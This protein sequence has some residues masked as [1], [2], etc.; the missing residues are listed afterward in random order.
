MWKRT[1][2]GVPIISWEDGSHITTS[3]TPES[4]SKGNHVEI[5]VCPSISLV[6]KLREKNLEILPLSD[7]LPKLSK[8]GWTALNSVPA[9]FNCIEVNQTTD[10]FITETGFLDLEFY[11]MT[12]IN[13]D[14][15]DGQINCLQ[16]KKLVGTIDLV[17]L[18]ISFD[19]L[20]SQ[21][22]SVL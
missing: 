1:S 3:A 21:L 11:V 4:I 8:I 6:T 13:P 16:G 2:G 14:L 17:D 7:T 9:G 10:K 19:V 5:R 15:C 20:L 18:M 12:H 22:L